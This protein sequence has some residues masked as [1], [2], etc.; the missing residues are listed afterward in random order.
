M[1]INRRLDFPPGDLSTCTFQK[2]K[3]PISFAL[4]HYAAYLKAT[5]RDDRQYREL[6]ATITYAL[7]ECGRH[8]G[9]RS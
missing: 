9:R 3:L 1:Q 4:E 8:G 7:G 5:N 6:P 2:N